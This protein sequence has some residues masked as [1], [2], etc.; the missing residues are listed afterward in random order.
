VHDLI[1]VAVSV[2]VHDGISEESDLTDDRS[3]RHVIDLRHVDSND[4]DITTRDG[5]GARGGPSSTRPLNLYRTFAEQNETL[6]TGR[7]CVTVQ[8]Q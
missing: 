2:A 5:R 6:R 7:T 4:D 3:R 8:V 1:N